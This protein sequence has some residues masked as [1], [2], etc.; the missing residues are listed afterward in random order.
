MFLSII[1]GGGGLFQHSLQNESCPEKELNTQKLIVGTVQTLFA[2]MRHFAPAKFESLSCERNS[3]S[4]RGDFF[5]VVLFIHDNN[6]LNIITCTN[7][8]L[9]IKIHLI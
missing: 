9:T 4:L 7:R 2:T 3:C 5:D 8:A 6:F 1:T